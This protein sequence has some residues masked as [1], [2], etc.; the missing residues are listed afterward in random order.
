MGSMNQINF[1]SKRLRNV[2]DFFAIN[3]SE[4]LPKK[5]IWRLRLFKLKKCCIFV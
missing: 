5:S 4:F 2:L 1:K 3:Q